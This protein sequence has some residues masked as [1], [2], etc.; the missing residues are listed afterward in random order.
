MAHSLD[1]N[2]ALAE[3][4]FIK[5]ILLPEELAQ[6]AD[7]VKRGRDRAAQE[8]VAAVASVHKLGAPEAKKQ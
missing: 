7:H 5:T 6:L 3:V 1:P 8:A 2:F 4:G